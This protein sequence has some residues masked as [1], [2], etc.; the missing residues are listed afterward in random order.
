MLEVGGKL[1]NLVLQGA[2][3]RAVELASLHRDAPL[4]AIFL[5]HFG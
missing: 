3:D 5:R 1:P 2:E 4:A